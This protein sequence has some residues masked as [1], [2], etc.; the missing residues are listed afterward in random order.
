VV[1]V[2]TSVSGMV[3]LL[4]VLILGTVLSLVCVAI[5]WLATEEQRNRIKESSDG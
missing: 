5:S 1:R 4:L 2:F 3:R